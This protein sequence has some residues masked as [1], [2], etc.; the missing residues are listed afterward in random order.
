MNPANEINY[1]FTAIVGQR[2]MKLALCLIAVQPKIGG[3]LIYGERG[4]AKTTA[5]RA[6]PSLLGGSRR[7]IELPL[8][9]SEERVVGTIQ[10]GTLMKSGERE[11]VP[12]LMAEADGA[13]GRSKVFRHEYQHTPLIHPDLFVFY[14][15]NFSRIRNRIRQ[16]PFR[17]VS[18]NLPAVVVREGGQLAHLLFPVHIDRKTHEI[19]PGL[20]FSPPGVQ[21][22][23]DVIS[24]LR[25]DGLNVGIRAGL[26]WVCAGLLG[27]RAGL[28]SLTVVAPGDAVRLSQ[29][30]V[31]LS[32][33]DH[34][35][36]EQ[37]VILILP[38]LMP[39][40]PGNFIILTVGVVIA[41]LGVQEFIP[42]EKH[43]NPAAHEEDRHGVFCQLLPQD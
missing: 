32:E 11:F 21:D 15:Y 27:G 2:D 29:Y 5:V 7:V 19:I 24:L 28:R 12:G 22:L 16:I 30:R 4:T 36:G 1:P 6:L 43:G 41:E 10:L 38:L 18:G 35:S 31:L 14:I 33:R 26:L 40:Q 23:Q 25:E 13:G 37:P 42:G 17:C 9:A 8:N 34:M 39:V 3:V 20:I